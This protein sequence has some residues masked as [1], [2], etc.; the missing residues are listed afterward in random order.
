MKLYHYTTID[1]FTK[2]LIS[3]ELLF[4]EYKSMNDLYERQKFAEIEISG[5][6]NIPEQIKKSEGGLID[7]FF[8]VLSKFQQISF[9]NDYESERGCLSPMMWGLYA[10]NEEGVCLE[11]DSQSLLGKADVFHGRVR[12]KS[13][14]PILLDGSDFESEEQVENAIVRNREEIFF[15]KHPH[16]RAENEYRVI[17]RF[18]SPLSIKGALTSIYLIEPKNRDAKLRVKL[19]QKL[20]E[21]NKIPIYY[22]GVCYENGSCKLNLVN[23]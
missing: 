17:S 7:Y 23:L 5:R 11:F 12:Y 9:C 1:S 22:I 6:T 20:I 4:H 18:P 8:S 21:G 2:I 16:W 14:K 3:E 19:V 15:T 10:K 13:V